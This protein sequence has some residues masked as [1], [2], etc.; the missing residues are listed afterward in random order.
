MLDPRGRRGPRRLTL[1]LWITLGLVL[2]L[3]GTPFVVGIF[4][5]GPFVGEA[6]M[7]LALPREDVWRVLADPQRAPVSGAL[8]REVRLLPS[9][10]GPQTWVEEQRNTTL[11]V[12]TIEASA[13]DHLVLRARDDSGALDCRWEIRSTAEGSGVRL[14]VVQSCEVTADG[15]QAPQLR[16]VM[17]FLGG[18][19]MGAQGYLR[20]LAEGL[21]QPA[22]VE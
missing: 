12:E 20:R 13:P 1:W 22:E 18:A 9:S 8:A 17:R 4:L 10:N 14:R 2:L 21:G 11:T 16:F 7:S 3:L 15:W 5:S 19:R 6:S